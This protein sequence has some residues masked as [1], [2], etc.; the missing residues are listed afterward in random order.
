MGMFGNRA[1][2]KIFGLQRQREAGEGRK[3]CS[4]SLIGFNLLK[5][6]RFKKKGMRSERQ[7][8]HTFYLSDITRLHQMHVGGFGFSL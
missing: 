7:V 8:T 5:L 1:L 4:G 6:P 2:I 3:I